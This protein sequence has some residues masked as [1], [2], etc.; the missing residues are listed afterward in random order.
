MG[1]RIGMRQRHAARTLALV[2]ALVMTLAPP[3]AAAAVGADGGLHSAFRS[4]INLLARGASFDRPTGFVSAFAGSRTVCSDDVLGTWSVGLGVARDQVTEISI[5]LDGFELATTR[6]PPRRFTLGGTVLY[7]TTV[8]I[9]VL[10]RLAAG[11]HVL[12]YDFHFS[13]GVTRNTRTVI[14]SIDCS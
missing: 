2:V 10:G 4:E 6:T 12:S 5:Q 8:G 7:G 9:P 13:N 14:T 3:A 11:Q 1:N